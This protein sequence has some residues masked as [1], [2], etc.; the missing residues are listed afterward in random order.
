MFCYKCGKE[1]RNDSVFC[2]Y[3]GAKIS[4]DLSATENNI[5]NEEVNE[6]VEIKEATPNDI[7]SNI[8]EKETKEIKDDKVEFLLGKHVIRYDSN[9]VKWNRIV[10][11][12]RQYAKKAELEL[13]EFVY[14]PLNKSIDDY[15]ENG[16]PLF[17]KI[18][19]EG[20]DEGVKILINEGIYEVDTKKLAEVCGENIDITRTWACKHLIEKAEE[21]EQIICGYNIEKENVKRSRG[22]WVGGGFG[23]KG[24]IKGKITADI[25]NAGAGIFH[26]IGEGMLDSKQFKEIERKKEVAVLPYRFKQCMVYEIVGCCLKIGRGINKI[27][28]DHNKVEAIDFDNTHD[29]ATKYRNLKKNNIYEEKQEQVLIELLKINVYHGLSYKEL[30]NRFKYS[31]SQLMDIFNYF[32]NPFF[33]FNIDLVKEDFCFEYNKERNNMIDECYYNYNTRCFRKTDDFVTSRGISLNGCTRLDV[34]NKYGLPLYVR[35]VD[36]EKTHEMEIYKQHSEL[37]GVRD[38]LRKSSYYDV[39]GGI[40]DDFEGYIEFYYDNDFNLL[41]VQYRVILY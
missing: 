7:K 40:N 6:I 21:I 13:W 30:F 16:I 12:L 31:A 35:A 18:I 29:L 37:E 32:N 14:N 2:A 39:Y 4:L 36:T 17:Y 34:Y 3:C 22:R 19:D 1:I 20:L 28:S 8:K 5:L 38:S 15:F 11:P 27:L 23:V 26:S 24:A 25:L 10:T 9:T 41:L 33:L